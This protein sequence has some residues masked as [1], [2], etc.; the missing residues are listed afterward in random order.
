MSFHVVLTFGDFVFLFFLAAF[1]LFWT[2]VIL[3]AKFQCW[4]RTWRK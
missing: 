4:K 3:N 2:Y 1:V